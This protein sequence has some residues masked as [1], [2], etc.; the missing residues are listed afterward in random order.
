MNKIF[1]VVIIWQEGSHFYPGSKKNV[2]TRDK[3]LLCCHCCVYK[4]GVGTFTF[5][6]KYIHWRM[7]MQSFCVVMDVFANH[8]SGGCDHKRFRIGDATANFLCVNLLQRQNYQS[9]LIFDNEAKSTN[10]EATRLVLLPDPNVKRAACV[11]IFCGSGTNVKT[12]TFAS[13]AVCCDWRRDAERKLLKNVFVFELHL[14]WCSTHVFRVLN[15]AEKEQS[16]WNI[17]TLESWRRGCVRMFESENKVFESAWH[18][19]Q[20]V[21]FV[22]WERTCVWVSL[23]MVQHVFKLL[24]STHLH[25]V[26]TWIDKRKFF[27]GFVSELQGLRFGQA[28]KGP[29]CE[30]SDKSLVSVELRNK[31]V[32]RFV[33]HHTL[34][35]YPDLPNLSL[36][37][38]AVGILS[39]W[40]V[41][42][43][44]D[45]VD[46][47]QNTCW[48]RTLVFLRITKPL[49]VCLI[50]STAG[51]KIDFSFSSEYV[52][53]LCTGVLN[54]WIRASPSNI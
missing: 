40:P 9:R 18:T 36:E 35:C 22:G 23:W 44:C 48:Q 34:K 3:K 32:C 46:E 33:Y 4:R 30:V 49:C 25:L 24:I 8:R 37:W 10:V 20:S 39:L 16:V 5:L 14:T 19:N 54:S 28:H 41:L 47:D 26:N 45:S 50:N 53:Q 15:Q 21:R 6:W 27:A 29:N 52:Q 42:M 51:C 17:C 7:E 43:K 38:N 11:N 1:C 13:D 31:I 12:L 2:A